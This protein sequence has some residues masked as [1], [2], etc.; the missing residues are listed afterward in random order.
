LTFIKVLF[1]GL[2]KTGQNMGVRPFV[3]KFHV[4]SCT[5]VEVLLVSIAVVSIEKNLRDEET[6]GIQISDNI[7]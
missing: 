5:A 4:L 1:H 6:G 2:L 3:G 7:P